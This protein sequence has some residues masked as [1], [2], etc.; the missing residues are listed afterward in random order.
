MEYAELI[1]ETYVNEF[2][3][4]LNLPTYLY[5][6]IYVRYL[7]EIKEFGLNPNISNLSWN[8]NLRDLIFLTANP[9]YAGQ[10]AA[11]SKKVNIDCRESIFLLKIESKKLNRNNIFIYDQ[12]ENEKGT[13]FVYQG[14]IPY[15]LVTIAFSFG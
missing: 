9:E 3:D 11:S 2:K 1:E 12:S 10:I 7:K 14:D 5:A 13:I 4:Q 8:D 6:P 15:S